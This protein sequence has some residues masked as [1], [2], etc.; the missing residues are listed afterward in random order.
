M[1][2][3]NQLLYTE[4]IPKEYS[5]NY[6]Y[7][8]KYIFKDIET[9]EKYELSLGRKQ[10][11]IYFEEKTYCINSKFINQTTLIQ[12]LEM[13]IESKLTTLYFDIGSIKN[14]I[15]EV[16]YIEYRF[17]KNAIESGY[18]YRPIPKIEYKLRIVNC[19]FLLE[20]HVIASPVI[21]KDN[22]SLSALESKNLDETFI[23]GIPFNIV[24]SLFNLN[25]SLRDFFYNNWKKFKNE[26]ILKKAEE[27]FSNFLTPSNI[28]DF[29]DTKKPNYYEKMS[30]MEILSNNFGRIFY[31]FTN[32]RYEHLSVEFN[33]LNRRFQACRVSENYK[34][35][36]KHKIKSNAPES[37]EPISYVIN[38]N[39][40]NASQVKNT[41]IQYK[42]PIA[43][44]IKVVYEGNRLGSL[45]SQNMPTQKIEKLSYEIQ[46]NKK[47]LCFDIDVIASIP[48]ELEEKTTQ[49]N[50]K[51]T[52]NFQ[53]YI[54]LDYVPKLLDMNEEEKNIFSLY[55]KQ[56]DKE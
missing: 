8:T 51:C 43:L 25:N 9:Y 36:H 55:I 52:E 40:L 5:P 38:T 21:T 48:I 49:T 29:F 3:K 34:F 12:Q 28:A 2:P 23:F 16:G 32:K 27:S 14:Y 31:I 20:M 30:S 18:K 50:E 45:N 17:S 22:E 26:L 4:T 42:E 1:Y 10:L 33:L 47:E 19:F 11:T 37:V 46:I 41:L 56:L 7:F 24:P 53:F 35:I 54:P 13:M 39:L 15:E 44:P 6:S